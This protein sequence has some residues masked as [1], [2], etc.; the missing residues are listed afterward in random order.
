M[1]SAKRRESL[2]AVLLALPGLLAALWLVAFQ[3]SLEPA[4][5][6]PDPASTLARAIREDDFEEAFAHIRAGQ[7]PNA[8]VAFRDPLTGDRE[9]ML[10]PL[11]IAA[12]YGRENSVAMLMSSG[13][14]ADAPGSRFAVC[15]ARQ[16]GHEEVAAM[17][18]RYAAPA[19]VPDTCPAPP[20]R[21]E[22]SLLAYVE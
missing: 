19:A 9:V 2:V 20:P 10:T 8:R 16:R 6:T 12:A 18:V 11:M 7:D 14:R 1:A 4:Y 3:L 21:D 17:I 13:A 5:A 22:A 15:V